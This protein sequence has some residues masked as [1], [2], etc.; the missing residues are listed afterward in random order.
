M[1]V[2]PRNKGGLGFRDFQMTQVASFVE[3]ACR[4][5]LDTRLC[6]SWM[7][8]RYTRMK[9]ID[10]IEKRH[11]DSATWRTILSEKEVMARCVQLRNNDD[12]CW[13]GEG[14]TPTVANITS[15]IRCRKANGCGQVESQRCQCYC[16]AYIIKAPK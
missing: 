5:W 1:M 3:R 12:L 6:S 7:R 11:N 10:K 8:K 15:T 9:G 2:L 16:G 13:K 14:S 4:I